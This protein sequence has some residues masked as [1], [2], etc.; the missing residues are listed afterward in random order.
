M[1]QD[2]LLSFGSESLLAARKEEEEMERL[3][4]LLVLTCRG[5]DVGNSHATWAALE[6]L[7]IEA[8]ALADSLCESILSV[9]KMMMNPA[10]AFFEQT[11][12]TCK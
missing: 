4:L 1:V 8:L 10:I 12:R 5:G 7:S 2:T 11:L 3:R 6:A 9:C